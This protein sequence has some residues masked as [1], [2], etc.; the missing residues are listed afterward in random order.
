MIHTQ[1]D[2]PDAMLKMLLNAAPS[3]VTVTSKEA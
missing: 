3:P 2:D 1:F